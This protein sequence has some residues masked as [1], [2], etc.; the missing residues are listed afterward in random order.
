VAAA[1]KRK[2][3]ANTTCQRYGRTKGQS[4]RKEGAVTEG[5]INVQVELRIDSICSIHQQHLT[6]TAS[7]GLADVSSRRSRGMAH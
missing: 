1:K 7:R 3:S 6:C 2:K 4:L 5:G